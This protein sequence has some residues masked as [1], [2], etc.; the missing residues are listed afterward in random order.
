[1]TD[2]RRR[3]AAAVLACGFL[4]VASARQAPGE[5]I[6]RVLAIVGDE[7]ILASDVAAAREFG[8]ITADSTA[9][10][11]TDVLPRLIDRAL[12]LAEVERYAPGEP[13]AMA[14]ERKLADVRVHFPS[15]DSWEAALAR[16]GLNERQLRGRLRQELLIAEYFDQRFPVAAPTEDD[17]VAFYRDHKEELVR[18]DQPIALDEMRAEI[19]QRIVAE[20]RR[21]RVDEWVAGLRRRAQIVDLSTR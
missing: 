3:V 18:Q 17:V 12:I 1:M 20:R 6:D 5:I 4:S 14:I 8:L 19:V 7:L 15:T 13:D 9:D 2:P 16:T 21:P 10:A 11:D